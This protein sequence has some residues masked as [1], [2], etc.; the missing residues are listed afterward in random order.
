MTNILY[1][2]LG[3]KRGKI[4]EATLE[5]GGGGAKEIADRAGVARTAFYDLVEPLLQRGLIKKIKSGGRHSFVASGPE[6][7]IQQEEQKV[8]DLK[9]KLPEISARMN[10]KS[11]KPRITYF[12][13]R[14]MQG[15]FADLFK[16]KNELL[17]FYTPR[18]LDGS[19][20]NKATD[21]IKERIKRK[22]P[23]RM[24]AGATPDALRF[25][26]SDIEELRESRLLPTEMFSSNVE[27]GIYG[28]TVFMLNL[29]D[30]FAIMIV[31]LSLA[32]VMRQIFEIIWSSG[33]ILNI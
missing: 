29:K 24:I 13:G 3:D 17:M 20:S 11:T 14:Q 5:L 16:S 25:K 22:I 8:S 31:N 4:Y 2:L 23:L 30:N 15:I 32:Q 9:K 10:I 28:S 7:L 12:E 18:F 21:L 33:K 1:D 19:L 27:I 6:F 26:R